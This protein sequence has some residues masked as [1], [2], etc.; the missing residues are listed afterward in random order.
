MDSR[1][2]EAPAELHGARHGQRGAHQE[3]RPPAHFHLAAPLSCATLN[4][5]RAAT[6][7][8]HEQQ[9]VISFSEDSISKVE[10]EN[11]HQSQRSNCI[12]EGS[13]NFHI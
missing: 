11:A 13:E 7:D 5:I 12:Q 4:Y 10:K 8:R 3:V 9:G 2:S 1:E 6:V